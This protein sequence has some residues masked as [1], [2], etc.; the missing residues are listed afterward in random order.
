VSSMGW[1]IHTGPFPFMV[2]AYVGEVWL[3]RITNG[4]HFTSV[5]VRFTPDV[6]DRGIDELA[7]GVRS[8]LLSRGRSEVETSLSWT[9]P[10]REISYAHPTAPPTYWGGKE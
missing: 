2:P 6:R 4:S 8:A 9:E 10:P 3:W 5:T 7:D 1:A